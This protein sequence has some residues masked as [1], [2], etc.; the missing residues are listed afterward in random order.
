MSEHKPIDGVVISP[1]RHIGVMELIEK[2]RT[3]DPDELVAI[4]AAQFAQLLQDAA[5]TGLFR[6]G[7]LD[8]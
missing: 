7:R 6:G 3:L 1:P 4:P 8:A 2:L 5:A